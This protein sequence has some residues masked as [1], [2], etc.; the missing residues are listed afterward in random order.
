MIPVVNFTTA[1][2]KVYES[3]F[4]KKPMAT[5]IKKEEDTPEQQ[6]ALFNKL[7]FVRRKVKRTILND[8]VLDIVGRRD[9]DCIVELER[10]C[11]RKDEKKF[12]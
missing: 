9:S 5:S 7:V 10:N 8:I 11:K 1:Q 12:W 2:K 6:M 3:R 4:K